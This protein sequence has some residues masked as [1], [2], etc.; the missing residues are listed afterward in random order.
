LPDWALPNSHTTGKGWRARALRRADSRAWSSTV[1]LSN[2]CRRRRQ[3]SRQGLG[4]GVSGTRASSV[5]VKGTRAG[6][7]RVTGP[8]RPECNGNVATSQVG[9][10]PVLPEHLQ[11]AGRVALQAHRLEVDAGI[12]VAIAAVDHDEDGLLPRFFRDHSGASSGACF[13]KRAESA[14]QA[15]S[16]K[17]RMRPRNVAGHGVAEKRTI[18]VRQRT[19]RPEDPAYM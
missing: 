13:T 19:E 10:H 15:P 16:A 8:E 14:Y 9:M 3:S 2:N 4:S 18:H 12:P 17:R 1:G 6:D 5:Y 7:R 11:P